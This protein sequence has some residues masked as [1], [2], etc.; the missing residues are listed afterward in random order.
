MENF[1]KEMFE[2]SI[3]NSMNFKT[4]RRNQNELA[5]IENYFHHFENFT[6]TFERQFGE[7]SIVSKKI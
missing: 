1:E 4:R 3:K 5:T 2:K 7:N 6:T